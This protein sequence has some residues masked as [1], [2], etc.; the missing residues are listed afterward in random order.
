MP[1]F[2][3]FQQG[4]ERRTAFTNETAP[5]LGRF[6]A[7][8]DS[9]RF[10]EGSGKSLLGF[11]VDRLGAAF[12]VGTSNDEGEVDNGE[13]EGCEGVPKWGKSMKDLWLEPKQSAVARVVDKWWT[14]WTVLVVLPAALVSSFCDKIVIP[15]NFRWRKRP[16]LAKG[17]FRLILHIDRLSHGAPYHFR[18]T[19]SPTTKT[20][21]EACHR[22]FLDIGYQATE[23]PEFRSTSGSSCLYIMDSTT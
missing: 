15:L 11:N 7:V 12:G 4:S 9:P 3:A 13:D 5:L 1:S 22:I 20:M 21:W 17:N 19:S 10:S 14:R 8:P 2:F 18:N 6:R 16:P 23:K